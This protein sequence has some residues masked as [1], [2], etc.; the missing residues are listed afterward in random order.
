[1]RIF[2][3][4]PRPLRGDRAMVVATPDGRELSAAVDD[5]GAAVFRETFTPGHYTV[6]DGDQRST[7]V[8]EVDPRESD[9]HWQEI[10]TN[11][12]EASGRVAVAVPRWRMLVLLIALLLAIESLLRRVRGREHERPD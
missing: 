10:A 5:D 2:V 6:R 7:F 3:G 1:S 8:V 9:T 4:E 12:S 11:D